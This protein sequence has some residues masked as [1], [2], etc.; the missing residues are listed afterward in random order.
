MAEVAEELSDAVDAVV[1]HRIGF[2]L[3]LYRDKALPRLPRIVALAAAGMGGASGEG[4]SDEDSSSD[5]ESGPPRPPPPPEF[6]II[7]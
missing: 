2:T 3:V 7:S 1:V 6:R 4:G 5:D